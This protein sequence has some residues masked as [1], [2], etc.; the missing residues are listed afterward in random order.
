MASSLQQMAHS[1]IEHSRTLINNDLKRIC[2]EEGCPQTGNK[3]HLQARVMNRTLPVARCPRRNPLTAP[4]PV[5]NAALQKS[6]TATLRRLQHRI[7]NHGE[8]PASTSSLNPAAPSFTLPPM[9][10]TN[11][12]TMGNGFSRPS[13]APAYASQ[14]V[15]QRMALAEPSY[16]D[17]PLSLI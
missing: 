3:V 1:M 11:G 8:A 10:A 9:P 13:P 17:A 2:K 5:I 4:S 16:T 7:Q 12:F 14:T 6:E 15:P